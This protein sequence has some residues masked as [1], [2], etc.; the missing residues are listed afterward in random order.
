MPTRSCSTRR[1]A[2]RLSETSARGGRLL[3]QTSTLFPWLRLPAS[4][5]ACLSGLRDGTRSP[6]EVC[7]PVNS[8]P[9][10]IGQGLG[11]LIEKGRAL[12]RP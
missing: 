6:G 8:G 5:P 3:F 10:P 2:R 12:G 9:A 1:H 11:A 7:S 4:L